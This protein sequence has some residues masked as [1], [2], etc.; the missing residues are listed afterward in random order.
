MKTQLLF[1]FLASASATV[2][3]DNALFSVQIAATE[4]SSLSFFKQNTSFNTL[5][6]DKSAMGLTKIKLGAY[7][8]YEEAK[9]KLLSI[10]NQG[11]ADAFIVPYT[12]N[13]GAAYGNTALKDNKNA[14]E[15]PI[16]SVA[17][18][19]LSHEQRGKIVYV[20]GVLHLHENGKFILLSTY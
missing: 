16:A 1:L 9:I 18:P 17:W 2:L 6:A 15:S 10:R 13:L 20:D 5:Y 8:S 3:A 7:N 19:K 14:L 11:F 4:S 12:K